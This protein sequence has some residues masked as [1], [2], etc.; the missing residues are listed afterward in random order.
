MSI[1]VLW[2]VLAY[3]LC[4]LLSR[5]IPAPY[6]MS[7]QLRFTWHYR[8]GIVYHYILLQVERETES[9]E[10]CPHY[11]VPR[12]QAGPGVVRLIERRPTSDPNT[13]CTHRLFAVSSLLVWSA[14]EP[15]Y[16]E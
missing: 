12:T 1:N 3:F 11:A 13:L 7:L 14:D 4:F 6:R 15:V 16:T 10:T 8:H 9:G 2:C 5:P